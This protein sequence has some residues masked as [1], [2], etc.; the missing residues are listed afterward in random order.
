MEP[1]KI[2]DITIDRCESCG[3]I[4]LDAG[5]LDRLLAV[6]DA[7]QKV[8]TGRAFS[9]SQA[10]AA[11]RK[12]PRDGTLLTSLAHHQQKHVTIDRCSS[13][14]GIFLDAGELKDLSEFTLAERM[15]TLL[16]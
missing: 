16:G 2:G 10:Q 15:R 3:G 13:C 11:I 6:K 1:L 14:M 4:W 7:P 8:D 12:C 9:S 5:E